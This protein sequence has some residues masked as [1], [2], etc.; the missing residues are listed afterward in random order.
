MRVV[1]IDLFQNESISKA[2]HFSTG[3]TGIK[4]SLKVPLICRGIAQPDRI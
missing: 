1:Y 2:N 4:K 3:D